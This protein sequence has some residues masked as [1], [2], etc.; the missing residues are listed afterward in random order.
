MKML[1]LAG[2]FGTRL[3]SVLADFPKALAPVGQAPFLRFQLE[4][5]ITQGLRSFVFLL[6]SQTLKHP[7]GLHTL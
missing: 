2:G 6:H 5:W 3:Q 4:H 1:V 7:K